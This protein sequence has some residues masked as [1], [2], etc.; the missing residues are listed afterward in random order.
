VFRQFSD[1]KS[2]GVKNKL[3]P[4][5]LPSFSNIMSNFYLTGNSENRPAKFRIKQAQVE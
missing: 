3:N 2:A 1:G 5:F 4:A